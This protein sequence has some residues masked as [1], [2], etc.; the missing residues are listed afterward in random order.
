MLS[1]AF[2]GIFRPSKVSV[3]EAK[4]LEYNVRKIQLL[5]LIYTQGFR[6]RI[7]LSK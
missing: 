5:L 1:A 2:Q 6:E 7:V 3:V 4:E